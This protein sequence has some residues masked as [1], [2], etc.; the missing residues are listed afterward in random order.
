MSPLSKRVK[1]GGGYYRGYQCIVSSA[2][3][4]YTSIIA[5]TSGAAINGITITPDDYGASDTMKVEHFNDAAGTG[6]CMAILAEDL[7]N[8]GANSSI[9]LDFPA[10]ELVNN[11]ECVKFT[12]IN[13][14]SI[15]MNVYLIAEFM[16]MRK[17]A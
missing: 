5:N 10:A 8:C 14:A 17:T 13:T 9:Q 4:N 12:Y 11:G 15:A 6:S 3:G 7:H 16:G 2:P 1:I